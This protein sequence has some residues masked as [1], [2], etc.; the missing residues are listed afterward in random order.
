VMAGGRD[1]PASA[2]PAPPELLGIHTNFAGVV[3]PEVDQGAQIGNPVPS[4]LSDEERHTV[5]Q[6]G[7]L[8]P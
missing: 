8:Y 4:D 2:E 5:E 6:L 3:P 1:A 7:D